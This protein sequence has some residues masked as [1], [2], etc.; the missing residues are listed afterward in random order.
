MFRYYLASVGTDAVKHYT[1]IGV[2][3][4]WQRRCKACQ[5]LRE[6]DNRGTFVFFFFGGHHDDYG[7]DHVVRGG[8]P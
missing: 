2:G 3:V 5:S 1:Y 7:V 8:E 4:G 6:L